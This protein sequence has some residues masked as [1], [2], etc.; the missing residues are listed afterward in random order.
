MKLAYLELCGFR[1]YR[2]RL[3][4]DFAEDFTIIDGRN[5]VGKSTIFDAIEFL[6]T[7]EISR[8]R[9]IKADRETVADYVWWTGKGNPPEARYVKAGFLDGDEVF[10][11]RRTEFEPPDGAA[12]EHIVD[13]LC[14]LGSA[15][16]N[17]IY[18]LCSSSI[19]RDEQIAA[20]SLDLSEAE[21][22][23]LLRDSLGAS[24]ARKWIERGAQLVST[25]KNRLQE[26]QRNVTS[27]SSDLTAATRRVDDLRANL[28][29]D[30]VLANAARRAQAFTKSEKAVDQLAGPV[31]E[32]IAQTNAEIEALRTLASQWKATEQART[33][34]PELGKTR[35]AA[36]AEERAA[37]SL[38]EESRKRMV[39]PPSMLA[40]QARDLIT[41][42]N[43]GRQL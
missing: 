34:V 16:Q 21:R 37:T 30:D 5:G 28:I 2:K 4:L 17:P 10:G 32:W 18:Q 13:G 39:V 40:Q 6:L 24:D 14:D 25:T 43:L 29:A 11:I 41:L 23:A 1:G 3:R 19:I 26:A 7:G 38:V 15:P 12:L 31:R 9:D 35:D 27:L 8:Y 36:V 22:Y 33:S 20:L 42:V